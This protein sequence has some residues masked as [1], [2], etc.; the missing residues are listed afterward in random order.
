MALTILLAASAMMLASAESPP[1]L[2]WSKHYGGSS[3]DAA[4][5]LVQTSD[6]GFALAGFTQSAPAHPNGDGWL[7]K[8]DAAGT[9]VE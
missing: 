1:T 3:T 7:V 8:T 5:A 9:T 2:A 6:G 4:N